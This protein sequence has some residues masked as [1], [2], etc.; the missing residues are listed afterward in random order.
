[1][2]QD[3]SGP[4]L[5][6]ADPGCGKSVLA[7][8]LIDHGLP[9]SA[10]CTSICYFFFKDQDQNTCRQA[11]CALLHQLFSQKP[12]LIAKHAVPQYDKNGET[13]RLQTSFG[14]FFRALYKIQKQGLQF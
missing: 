10:T 7:K 11:L 8:Y 12:A 2:K 13:L 14:T 3:E 9:Q 1:L 4:L 5:I 6:T